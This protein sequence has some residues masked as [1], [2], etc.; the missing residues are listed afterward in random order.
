MSTATRQTINR[1]NAQ[2]STGPRTPE[3]K[4]TVSQNANR[5]NLTGRLLL[6]EDEREA[7]GNFDATLRAQLSPTGALEITL[8]EQL[9]SS[10]WNLRRVEALE[11]EAFAQGSL[12]DENIARQLD[13]LSRYRGQH[14]R[15]FYRAL[16][17]LQTLQTGREILDRLAQPQKTTYTPLADLNKVKRVGFVLSPSLKAADSAFDWLKAAFEPPPSHVT[18]TT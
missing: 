18:G 8:F 14:E 1:E 15:S 11:A 17:E 3:G 6:R 5:H 4:A 9:I 7:F 13:R 12:A 2:H 10:G 16:H